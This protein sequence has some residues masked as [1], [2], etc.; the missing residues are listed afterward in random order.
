MGVIDNPPASTEVFYQDS[1]YGHTSAEDLGYQDYASTAEH[2]LLWARLLIEALTPSGG[3]IL[4][5]GCADGF[6]LRRLSGSYQRFGIEVNSSAAGQAAA[7]GVTVLARD[8]ADP[9]MTSG[10]CGSFDIITSLA[11]FEHLLDLSGAL[12]VCLGLLKPNG[13]LLFEV[14]LISDRRDSAGWFQSSYEHVYYPTPRG[15][16]RLLQRYADIRFVASESD[17]AGFPPTYVAAGTRDPEQYARLQQLFRVMT[18]PGLE[19]LDTVATR[20]NL[21]Y[22]VVHCFRPT[23]ERVLALPALLDIASSPNL[24]KRLMELWHADATNAGQARHWQEAHAA[25]AAEAT[26][27]IETLTAAARWHEQ[28]AHNWQE[29]HAS[30]AAQAAASAASVEAITGAVRWHEQQAHNWQEAH[31]SAAAQAAALA[32]ALAEAATSHQ[33]EAGK[34]RQDHAALE[35]QVHALRDVVAEQRARLAKFERA[36]APLLALRRVVRRALGM[37]G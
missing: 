10:A 4:D 29:A 36:L 18:Q 7:G 15:M 17:I 16:E 1:Y 37:G 21:A 34:W 28:Q 30:A 32:N 23:P 25:V 24:L 2:A 19:G 22:H 27:K 12:G 31:A 13:V 5:V 3:R 33:L 11:T 14:P 6:L 8:I 9:L 26:A 20:L 35:Q